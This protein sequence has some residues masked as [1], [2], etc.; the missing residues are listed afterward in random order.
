[1]CRAATAV[2][3]RHR[4][5][6]RDAPRTVIQAFRIDEEPLL[7]E[8]FDWRFPQGPVAPPRRWLRD[9]RPCASARPSSAEEG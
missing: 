5:G 4:G 7:H 1:M 9:R 6:L 2:A 8:T 3:Q